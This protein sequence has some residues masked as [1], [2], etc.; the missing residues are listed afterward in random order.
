MT[1]GECLSIMELLD[2]RASGGDLAPSVSRHVETCSRCSALFRSLPEMSVPESADEIPDV[3]VAPFQGASADEVHSGQIWVARGEEPDERF[4]VL[5][6]GRRRDLGDAFVVVPT[7]SNIE[8]ATDLDLIVIEA[9]PASPFAAAVWNYGSVKRDQLEQYVGAVSEETASRLRALYRYVVAGV[10]DTPREGVGPSLAGPNDPRHSAR[11]MQLEESKPLFGP[12]RRR[13]SKEELDSAEDQS[14]F[15]TLADIVQSSFESEEWDEASL[16]ESSHIPHQDLRALIE[17]RLDL[18][19]QSDADSV[20]AV[21]YQLGMDEEAVREPLIRGLERSS[22]GLRK[23]TAEQ[24][25]IAA[26]SFADV[27]EERR[28]KKIRDLLSEVDDSVGA[29]AQA[30]HSYVETV[31]QRL[32]ELEQG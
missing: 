13:F 1:T 15:V 4:L 24:V 8:E 3:V 20:A 7:R 32:E 26:R 10:G 31:L 2:L 29:R 21:V 14:L 19:D 25:R 16:I 28:K 23:G 6:V 11:A 30:I 17:D 18:T 22:G 9:T 27:S 5:T 12:M